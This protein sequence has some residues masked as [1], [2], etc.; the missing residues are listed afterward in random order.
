ML[1][2]VLNIWKREKKSTIFVGKYTSCVQ[3]AN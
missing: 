1:N 3:A 2:V